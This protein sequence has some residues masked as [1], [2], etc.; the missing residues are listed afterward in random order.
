MIYYSRSYFEDRLTRRIY[1]TNYSNQVSFLR[2]DVE[3][4]II[5]SFSTKL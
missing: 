4:V 3:F 5:Q 1:V 2:F